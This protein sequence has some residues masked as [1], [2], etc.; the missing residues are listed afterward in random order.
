M[1]VHPWFNLQV[2]PCMAHGHFSTA[3]TTWGYDTNEAHLGLG[4]IPQLGYSGEL[5]LGQVGGRRYDSSTDHI[6]WYC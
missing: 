5:G 4:Q 2:G 3:T 1:L 6:D